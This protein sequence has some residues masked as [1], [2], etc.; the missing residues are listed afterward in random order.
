MKMPRDLTLLACN[1]LQLWWEMHGATEDPTTAIRQIV[2]RITPC[3]D[4]R[5]QL[6]DALYDRWMQLHAG[7]DD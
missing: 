5:R 1:D 2:V 4:I 3:A 6:E 7:T